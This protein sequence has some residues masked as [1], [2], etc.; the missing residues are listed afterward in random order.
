MTKV[1]D[2]GKGKVTEPKKP[3]FFPLRTSGAL[4]IFESKGPIPQAPLAAE[5]MKESPVVK[6]NQ[7]IHLL[8]WPEL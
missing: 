7:P 3:K 5:P 8:E 2:K 6:K 1:V 4:N